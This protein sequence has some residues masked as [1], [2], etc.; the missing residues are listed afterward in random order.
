MNFRVILASQ[1]FG[2]LLIS[3]CSS[4]RGPMKFPT[5]KV[6]GQVNYEGK[7]A[8]NVQVYLFPLAA[9]TMPDIP[10]NPRAVSDKD[11]KFEIST[12][13]END[14][15]PDGAPA[16]KYQILMIWPDGKS[17]EEDKK[18]RFLGWYGAAYSKLEVFVKEG[19][20]N[21]PVIQVPLITRAPDQVNGIPGRN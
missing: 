9:P 15:T 5:F 17:K 21:I 6:T 8:E 14:G 11:G 18:D 10:S 7:P 16:G 12:Y 1:L 2:L 20:N 13:A 19:E 4:E 3:G